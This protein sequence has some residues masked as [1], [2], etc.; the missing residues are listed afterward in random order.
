MEGLPKRKA[1]QQARE[2]TGANLLARIGSRRLCP[3]LEV[4]TAAERLASPAQH[5]HM[6][7]LICVVLSW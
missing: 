6:H 7:A 1:T 5:D 2:A 3:Y 4:I